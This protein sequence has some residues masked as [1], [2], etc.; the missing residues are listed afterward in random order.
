MDEPF[1]DTR[2]MVAQLRDHITDLIH[3]EDMKPGDRLPAESQ[4]TARFQVSRPTL[5]EALKLMEQDGSIV[6]EHGR[7]RFISATSAIQ[8]SR[9]ITIFESVSDMSRHY[10]YNPTN[11]VLS[12]EE[13]RPPEEVKKALKLADDETTVRL[14]RLRFE[15]GE[16]IIYCVDY[17]PRRILPASIEH[18][19]WEDS[20]LDIMD[21]CGQRP[22]MSVASVSSVILPE[23]VVATNQLQD[24]GPA[25]LICETCFSG[26]GAPVNYAMDYHRGSYFSF[27]FARK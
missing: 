5:R 10:G 11:K 16:P 25:L 2:T 18:L 19:A 9:P 13:Q 4:L 3:R 27:S 21:S 15:K 1:R 23:D 7:G 24:F 14:E 26:A 20:L 17:V 8:V 22:R 6:V 12:V